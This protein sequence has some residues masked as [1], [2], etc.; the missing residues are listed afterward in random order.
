MAGAIWR[1]LANGMNKTVCGGRR[2][3][4][5]D[6]AANV[7]GGGAPPDGHPLFAG[8]GEVEADRGRLEGWYH[9]TIS[10]RGGRD[11][12]VQPYI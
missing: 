4:E 7:P 1:H 6:I 3:G 12:E 9:D 10:D 2:S 11:E 8:V 5:N